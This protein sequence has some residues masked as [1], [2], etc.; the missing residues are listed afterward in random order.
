M[1]RNNPDNIYPNCCNLSPLLTYFAFFTTILSL[2][3][4]KRLK[5][6]T[7]SPPKKAPMS[8]EECIELF[9]VVS[10]SKVLEIFGP[11]VRH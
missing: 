9:M 1:V 10:S 2:K 6:N 5:Q 4:R 11:R 3:L 8:Q 7:I